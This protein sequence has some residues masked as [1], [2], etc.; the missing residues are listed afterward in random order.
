MQSA[1][2]LACTVNNSCSGE[3]WMTREVHEKTVKL[4]N[5]L[6]INYFEWPGKGP[7][8]LLLHPTT[9]YGRIWEWLADAL[10][11]QFHIF[12]HDQRGHGRSGRPDGSYSAEEYADDAA[13][14]MEAVGIDRA[15]VFGHSLG[16]RVGQALAGLY[17]ER[18]ELLLLTATHRSNF[19]GT[20]EEAKSVL[21]TAANNLEHPER[22]PSKADAIAY[23]RARWPWSPDPDHALEHRIAHNFDHGVDGSV[24]ARYDIVR[25]S[26]GLMHLSDNMRP[27]AAAVK[28][29]VVILRAASGKLSA[30][31]AA[32]LSRFWRDAR[33]VD[34]EGTY[35][36]QLE[37]PKGVAEV[38]L[39]LTSEKR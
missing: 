27:H 18:V 5:G 30:E 36:V 33:V 15:I 16:S 21:I 13:L 35:A 31:E 6:V 2:R 25:V 11:D 17:P 23:M 34:V 8:L 3:F 32:D 24:S 29:P 22:F 38:I 26:Q 20:R 7:K 9:G 28:C 37:N 1:V 14:F 10:G 39:A 19:Y 4:P 12:A